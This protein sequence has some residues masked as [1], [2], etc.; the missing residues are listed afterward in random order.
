MSPRD[1]LRTQPNTVGPVGSPRGDSD[2]LV[3][4]IRFPVSRRVTTGNDPERTHYRLRSEI[5]VS[6]SNG[7]LVDL[8]GWSNECVVR[9]RGTSI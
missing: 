1:P 2:G 5:L 3:L 4:G 6:G 8:V 7:R 9:G